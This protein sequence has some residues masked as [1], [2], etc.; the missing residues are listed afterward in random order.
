M[1]PESAS[2]TAGPFLH[3]GLTPNAC[4]LP[5]PGGDLGAAMLTGPATGERVVLSLRVI[6]GAGAPV[7][8]ALVE[9]WQPDAA[10]RFPGTP[11]ADPHVSGFGRAAADAQ[12][13]LR[14]ETVRPGAAAPAAPHVTLMIFARGVNMGLHTRAY[15]DGDPRNPDDPLLQALRPRA[16][17][18]LARPRDGAW[19]LDVRLQGDG[20]TAFLDV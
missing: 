3:I 18:L 7:A 5:V 8:D 20:E 16:E 9:A 10:G 14:F 13:R 19:H 4:G 1:T 2:Q 17:T 15:F 6:D 11:G 12:G